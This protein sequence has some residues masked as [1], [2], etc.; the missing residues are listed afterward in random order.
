MLVGLLHAMRAD[1]VA[2]RVQTWP[3]ENGSANGAKGGCCV[4]HA[5]RFFLNE[6]EK[7]EK[8]VLV[9]F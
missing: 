9:L 1:T 7:K 6:E 5:F 3:H 8:F 2:A 4:Y